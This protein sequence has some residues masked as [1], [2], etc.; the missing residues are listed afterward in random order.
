MPVLHDARFEPDDGTY[1]ALVRRVLADEIGRG[2]GSNFVVRRSFLATV[3]DAGPRTALAVFRRLLLAERG[4][5]WTFVVHGYGRTLV[6][7]SPE[8][9]VSLAGG[10]ATM[11]PVSG[12]YRYPAGGPT[13]PDL[14]CFLADRK[15][16][17]KR[18]YYDVVAFTLVLLLV[19]GLV[20]FG[21]DRARPRRREQDGE[22]NRRRR[23]PQRLVAGRGGALV[24]L[25]QPARD[26]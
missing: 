9:H 18:T 17:G 19:L 6:G 15:D 21:L 24:S 14:A 12:T 1:G 5:Y 2:A 20:L 26:W 3:D 16:L 10:V 13:V 8:R 25:V 22:R 11:N 4:A 7:A 23:Q